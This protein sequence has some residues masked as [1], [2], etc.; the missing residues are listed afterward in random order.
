MMST[1]TIHHWVERLRAATLEL[2]DLEAFEKLQIED[3]SLELGSAYPVRFL[4]RHQRSK[5]EIGLAQSQSRSNR[6]DSQRLRGCLLLT[7][8]A[9]FMTA[10]AV[11]THLRFR[12]SHEQDR[13]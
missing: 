10:M 12:P 5:Q 7:S 2:F 1:H 6:W 9:G 8:E 11:M 3:L 4:E 13:I